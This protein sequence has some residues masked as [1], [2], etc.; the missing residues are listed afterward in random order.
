MTCCWGGGSRDAKFVQEI[1][2]RNELLLL[3]HSQVRVTRLAASTLRR[4]LSKSICGTLFLV[5]TRPPV[6]QP[7]SPTL[8]PPAASL[9]NATSPF[10]L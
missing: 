6:L 3:C 9:L 7:A 2:L 1:M 4:H 8:L 10:V 5:M